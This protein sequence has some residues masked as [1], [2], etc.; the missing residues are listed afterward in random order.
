MKRKALSIHLKNQNETTSQKSKKS[1]ASQ[2]FAPTSYLPK[3]VQVLDNENSNDKNS[4]EQPISSSNLGETLK[5]KKG[6]RV[7]FNASNFNNLIPQIPSKP[8][9]SPCQLKSAELKVQSSPVSPTPEHPQNSIPPIP[10]TL[11]LE[12]LYFQQYIVKQQIL[13]LAEK[14]KKTPST[15]PDYQLLNKKSQSSQ[16]EFTTLDQ[17]L[18]SIKHQMQVEGI[19]PSNDNV[20]NPNDKKS[21][22]LEKMKYNINVLQQNLKACQNELDGVNSLLLNI[23]SK[24]KDAASTADYQNLYH[25][26]QKLL[27][28]EGNLRNFFNFQ[29]NILR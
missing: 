19:K 13:H 6:Q 5:R 14:I 2:E 3:V 26:H 20:E 4:H 17:Q 8:S 28:T 18:F 9:T 1:S 22:D 23:L 10:I 15:S 16:R 11:Q 29:E 7:N 21:K 27:Y 25:K 12:F 24:D